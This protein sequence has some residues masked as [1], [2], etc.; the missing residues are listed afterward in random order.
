M[1]PNSSYVQD[2]F[3][4]QD[5]LMQLVISIEYKLGVVYTYNEE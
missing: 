4:I 5:V 1:Y 2:E 3:K